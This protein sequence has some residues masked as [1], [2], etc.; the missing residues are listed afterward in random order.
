MYFCNDV[1]LMVWEPG[2]FGETDFGHQMVVRQSA[3]T[4]T[5][6]AL[7]MAGAVL[8]GVLPGMVGQIVL[9]DNSLTQLLEV[10][11]VADASHATVSGLRGRADSDLVPPL[12]GGAVNVSVM[13]FRAQIAAV[14]DELLGLVGVESDRDE[15]PAETLADLRGFRTAAVMGTLAAVFRAVSTDA[16]VSAAMLA[17]RD[18]YFKTY[19]ALRR[20]MEARVNGAARNPAVGAMGRE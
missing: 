2:I 9:A 15:D 10:V 5:G 11:L 6:N 12:V 3:G 8:E 14:G 16:E 1:D 18:F 7:A 13:T 20:R 4:L 19:L 17:K